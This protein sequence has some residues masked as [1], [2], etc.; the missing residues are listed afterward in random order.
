METPK[1][2]SATKEGGGKKGRAS[3][4]DDLKSRQ[5]PSSEDLDAA[6]RTL[7]VMVDC[8]K[9]RRAVVLSGAEGGGLDRVHE[10]ALLTVVA[11]MKS[12][13]RRQ[14]KAARETAAV[15]LYDTLHALLARELKVKVPARGW[16]KERQNALVPVPATPPPPTAPQRRPR[17]DGKDAGSPPLLP[18]YAQRLAEAL[19]LAVGEHRLNF[20][21]EIP[22]QRL[23]KATCGAI[24]R[25]RRHLDRKSGKEPAEVAMDLVV[26]LTGARR[27]NVEH[28]KLRRRAQR[29]EG[30]RLGESGRYFGATN[31]PKDWQDTHRRL[32]VPFGGDP[33]VRMAAWQLGLEEVIRTAV[34]AYEWCSL[35]LVDPDQID[36]VDA[37]FKDVEQRRAVHR[38][39]KQLAVALGGSPAPYEAPGC[40]KN[41][42][43]VW[44][45]EHFDP[46]Q[47]LEQC[48]N[49]EWHI[50]D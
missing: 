31:D 25:M 47:R 13:A 34:G 1:A 20:G 28:W 6:V 22:R 42:G 50:G 14:A 10:T 33:F 9:R 21:V 45:F 35:G 43:T 4:A 27:G 5:P 7:A 37:P 8:Y 40:P 17:L 16:P 49:G 38:A 18:E 12:A 2:D 48:A 44:R 36:A 26:T 46:G 30:P 24:E 3:N 41:T 19:S 29:G 15:Q 32:C 39:M 11:E 23:E